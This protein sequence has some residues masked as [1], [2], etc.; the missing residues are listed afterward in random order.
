MIGMPNF[1][2][3][4]ESLYSAD[5]SCWVIKMRDSGLIHTHE[6]SSW[7]SFN[8][9]M[10]IT[11]TAQKHSSAGAITTQ[12]WLIP[13]HR[14][15]LIS[16]FSSFPRSQ[17]AFNDFDILSTLFYFLAQLNNLFTQSFVFLIIPG[18]LCWQKLHHSLEPNTHFLLGTFNC[19]KRENK[20]L[21]ILSS[22][23]PKVFAGLEGRGDVVRAMWGGCRRW[24][25]FTVLARFGR[26]LLLL[27]WFQ[28][29]LLHLES[30]Y[31]GNFNL[32]TLEKGKKA[33]FIEKISKNTHNASQKVSKRCLS[34]M[35]IEK[36][37]QI[38]TLNKKRF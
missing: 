10:L 29:R 28:L 8:L 2:G 31:Y 18:Y 33:I 15:L 30:N 7:T 14:C 22:W 25:L 27:A 9:R 26:R 12:S 16:D 36:P 24:H 23:R 20:T 37:T 5:Y 17:Y 4:K 6:Q 34:C 35:F 13:L 3:G 19:V 1:K 11:A 38:R 21:V 32:F